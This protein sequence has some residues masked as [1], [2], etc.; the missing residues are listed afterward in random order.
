[1]DRQE[2]G[3][4]TTVR[5]VAGSPFFEQVQC[6]L[7]ATVSAHAL[8]VLEPIL[9]SLAQEGIRSQRER[10]KCRSGLTAHI[11]P[12]WCTPRIQISTCEPT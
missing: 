10:E 2:C 12:N 6:Q 3:R 1:M 8:I 5:A 9:A 11:F 4:H 7:L